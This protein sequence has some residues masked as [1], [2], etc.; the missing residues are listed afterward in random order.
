MMTSGRPSLT[1]RDAADAGALMLAVNAPCARVDAGLEAPVG[2]VVPLLLAGFFV[3]F[4]LGIRI[5]A[6]RFREL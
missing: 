3:D 4:F 6:K 1:G 5:V 2:G